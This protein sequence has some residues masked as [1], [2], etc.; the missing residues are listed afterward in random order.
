MWYIPTPKLYLVV[1]GHEYW[2]GATLAS[3]PGRMNSLGT[4]LGATR[5]NVLYIR[6][7]YLWTSW[8]ARWDRMQRVLT[9]G[10]SGDWWTEWCSLIQ[11][12]NKLMVFLRWA[13]TLPACVTKSWF[14]AQSWS[15]F[16]TDEPGVTGALDHPR[17]KLLDL[18]THVCPLG[19]E[20]LY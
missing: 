18:P 9:L 5:T 12:G 20:A 2:Q 13:I 14:H 10:T 17:I 8:L 15:L 1:W 11:H 19:V 7:L 4:R 3:Y 16:G 6:M